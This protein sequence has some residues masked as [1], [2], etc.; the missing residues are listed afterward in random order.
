[1][2]APPLGS[3]APHP[4][5]PSLPAA[6]PKR[7]AWGALLGPV[8]QTAIGGALVAIDLFTAITPRISHALTL[9][10]AVLLLPW[11]ASIARPRAPPRPAGSAQPAG[12]SR[13]LTAGVPIALLVVSLVAKWSVLEDAAI[14]GAAQYVPV[15]RTYASMSF[16]LSLFGH[17]G[18]QRIERF[19]ATAADHPARLMVLSFGIAALLGGVLLTLPQSLQ[20]TS[21]GSLVDGIFTATSA[22][23]VTGLAVNNLGQT[24]TLFGQAVILV[25]VQLG[26]LGIMVLSAFFAIVAG[27]RLRVRSAAVMAEMIDTDSIAS[28]RRAVSA[29][30]L[31]AVVIEAAGAGA[32]YASLSEDPD[33]ASG[34][35]DSPISGA[36]SHWWAAVFHSV[37]AF[38]NAGFSLFRDGLVPFAESPSVSLSI[39]ALIIL[40]G[41]GFPVLDELLKAAWTRAFGRRPPRLSLHARTVLWTTAVLLAAGTMMFLVLEWSRTMRDLPVP[42]RFLTAAFQSVTTR[43]AGFNTLDFGAMRASTLMCTCVLMFIGAGPGSTAGGIKITTVAVLYASL[44]AELRGQEAPSLLQRA[45]PTGTVRRATGLAFLSVVIVGAILFLLLLTERHDPMALAF[46]TVSAFATV[47]LSTGITP[48]LSVPGKLIVSAAMFAG[49]I[50]PLTLA[51]ALATRVRPVAYRLPEERVGIG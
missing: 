34:P 35:T 2:T 27:R 41:L 31:L 20:R 51:L 5:R 16:A 43:T 1:M 48:A 15:Y 26:G 30:V 40:G 8:S 17:V 9:A 36:G 14:D 6:A 12:A 3:I 25:L 28:F 22:V 11:A 18:A 44:R 23:C 50:G 42:A 19:F 37:S 38:C 13:W 29:I 49:R 24:Y 7:A 10:Q 33:V 4:G 32:L 39:M 45:I 47:G 21:D 46:E